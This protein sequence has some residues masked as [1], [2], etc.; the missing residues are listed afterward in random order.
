MV[1]N[2]VAGSSVFPRRRI[3]SPGVI[4]FAAWALCGVLVFL[5]SPGLTTTDTKLDLLINPRGFLAGARHIW[6]DIFPLGQIQ[7]QAYGYFFPQGLFFLLGDFLPPWIT[8]RL[9]WWLLLGLGFSGMFA[10]LNRVFYGHPYSSLPAR[11][12]AAALFTLSPRT[13]STLTAISSESWPVMLAPWVLLAL[14]SSP[15]PGWRHLT[16]SLLPIAAMGAVNATAT[17]AACIPA[18]IVL[19]L[20]ARRLLIPWILGCILVSSWWIG[21][22]LLLGRYSPPFTDFI[23]SAAVTTRWLN[24][25]EILRGTTSWSP[26][27]DNERIPGTLLS[28][29]PVFVF[30]TLTIAA[31]GLYGLSSALR[32]RQ[33]PRPDLWLVLLFTGVLILGLSAAWWLHFLDG[34]GAALRN[35]HKCDLLIRIP[36]CVGI[37][38]LPSPHLSRFRD[39]L[40][41]TPQLL[42]AAGILLLSLTATAPAWTGRL[43]HRGAWQELTPDW[44]A[45]AT[46]LNT[47]AAGTRTLI[48]PPSSFARQTWGWTRDEP[49]QPLLDVPWV[50][51]DAIPLVPPEAIRG[52]DGLDTMLNQ[53]PATAVA[54]LQRLGIGAVVVRGDLDSDKAQGV[55]QKAITHLPGQ[56]VDFGALSVFLLNPQQDMLLSPLDQ[57]ETVSGA[58]ESLSL[59]NSTEGYRP[60]QLVS[61][62]AQVLTDTPMLTERNYG[63]LDGA[64]S[65]PLA[66]GEPGGSRNKVKDYPSVGPKTC[67][68][69][70]GGE[71]LASSQASDVDSFG[72]ARAEQSI[73]AAVDQ[74]PATAWFPAPGKGSGQWIELHPDQEISQP[75][76]QLETTEDTDVEII[77]GSAHS[78]EK[79][80]AHQMRTI[81]VPGGR[82][83][84]IRVVISKRVGIAEFSIQG[85]PITRIAQL[86]TSSPEADT[87][88]FQRLWPHTGNIQRSFQLQKAQDFRLRLPNPGDEATFDG[89]SFRDGQVVHLEPGTHYVTSHSTWVYASA[90]P[91]LNPQYRH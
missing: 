42:A 18:G 32:R 57:V 25:A 38:T 17:L 29:Q 64:Q 87:I 51:R 35:L 1:Q 52:L 67:I 54:D 89:E 23:E 47:H 53:D 24:L 63:T 88:L 59:L 55:A 66:P 30:A 71:V 13:L 39:L 44:V 78:T 74:D 4:H 77:N 6:S 69:E 33:L 83:Q 21:P 45:A 85:H 7:N 56:R 60:R 80:R 3:N 46:Y 48:Y 16:L 91:A 34:P 75:V 90:A 68:A 15:R 72:G 26:F 73:S 58:G 27:A 50:V 22:L 8:E 41:P 14:L 19:L 61:G 36:L 81:P 28:T 5:N 49:A 43:A 11:V 20:Y 9:W 12:L 86:P 84:R 37:A 40:Y 82:A 10:L 2:T 62:N 31:L 70:D 65:A 79:L 76:I